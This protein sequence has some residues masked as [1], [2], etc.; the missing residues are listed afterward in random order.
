MN[1]LLNIFDTFAVVENRS[2]KKNHLYIFI[3][4]TSW[5]MYTTGDPKFWCPYRSNCQRKLYNS[6]KRKNLLGVCRSR[7]LGRYPGY[8][9]CYLLTYSYQSSTIYNSTMKVS[10]LLQICLK[11]IAYISIEKI[12]GGSL[13]TNRYFQYVSGW[14]LSFFIVPKRASGG[15]WMLMT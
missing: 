2:V 8:F 15:W 6:G 13:S 3:Y 7:C 4:C 11:I 1:Y 9:F 12:S 10:S 14:W 5:G